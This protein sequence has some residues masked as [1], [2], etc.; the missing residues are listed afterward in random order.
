MAKKKKEERPREYTRRQLSH[1]QKQK[2]RQ[3]IIF[4]TGIT[5]IAAI[6]LI[7]L[8]GW[9]LNEY[10]PLHQT[11]IR[12]GEREFNM[13]YYVDT[14]KIYETANPGQSIDII[15]MSVPIVIKQNELVRLAAQPLGI[16]IS[17]EEIKQTLEANGQPVFDAYVDVTRAQK[18][19][20]RLKDEYFGTQKVPVSDNQVHIMALLAES[21]SLATEAR[22]KLINGENFTA[23]VEQY[24]QDTYSKAVK[25]D[26]GLHP[27]VILQEETDSD[28]PLDFAFGAEAGAVSPPLSDN[29]TFKGIG[30]WLLKVVERPSDNGTIVQAL[31]LSSRDEALEIKA[32]LEAGENLGALA[33]QYS[34]YTPSKEKHGEL[35]LIAK[36]SDNT[37]TV[38]SM[39]FDAYVF[40][41]ATE[42]GKW[43]DPIPEIK[44][45]TRGGY[46]LVQVIEKQI[47][48]DLSDEDREYLI[49][50]AYTDWVSGL[51]LQYASE[52]DESGLT[53]EARA[54]AIER[55]NKELLQVGG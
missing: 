38:V 51:Y 7:V 11:L 13:A 14:L 44:F 1:F 27:R 31:Y 20:T 32:R 48:T 8:L 50:N 15:D 22:D 35:G 41:P 28:V 18:L 17:D 39:L 49:S 24:A 33:D 47:N 25:G 4:I 12:V 3:R 42:L 53:S 37:T 54:W 52:I 29:Q 23:L 55:A 16:T 2:R 9:Y 34:Q 19:E 26:F 46:W 36:P 21:E 6:L 43:S 10:R 30:Y 40:N 5:V 45:S